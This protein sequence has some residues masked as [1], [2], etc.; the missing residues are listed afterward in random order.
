MVSQQTPV[1]TS[2]E[3][4]SNE[5]G[6][7]SSEFTTLEDRLS[8]KKEDEE[9]ATSPVAPTPNG[10]DFPDGGFAAWCIVLGVS[11]ISL[12]LSISSSKFLM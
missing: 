5:R 8:E 10:G 9:I 2:T 12:F 7:T 3:L 4:E 11:S 6:L 1:S